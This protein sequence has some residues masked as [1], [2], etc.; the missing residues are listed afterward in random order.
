MIGR[1]DAAERYKGH[2]QVLESLPLILARF[3]AC[4][5]N[6]VGSGSDSERLLEKSKLLGLSGNVS[7]LGRLDNSSLFAAVRS[8]TGLL[9]PSVRE[10]FGFVY[11]Y[12]MWAGLPAVAIRGTVAE[13]VL[14]V[15]GIYAETQ[16]PE[17]IAAAMAEALSG[18]WPFSRESQLR[19][20]MNFSYDAFKERLSEFV[21][22]EAIKPV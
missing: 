18:A 15:C 10:G 19:Y 9:L 22:H 11:L 16:N 6:I 5:I 2:D 3:P 17:A 13:E 21:L 8:S 12:A 14:G 20:K 1:M 4:K 7:F